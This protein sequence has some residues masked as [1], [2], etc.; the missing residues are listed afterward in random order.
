MTSKRSYVLTLAVVSVFA[1]L[2]SSGIIPLPLGLLIMLVAGGIWGVT[3]GMLLLRGG[4]F[5]L[6]K[7]LKEA[8]ETK[9]EAEQRAYRMRKGRSMCFYG[10]F[11]ILWGLLTPLLNL[12][13]FFCVLY[14]CVDGN[15]YIRLL[16][17]RIVYRV[18][19]LVISP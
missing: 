1:F 13:V 18:L 6:T 15:M 19:L 11:L 4:A 7:Q 14:Y 17:Q 8:M 10:A 9:P 5:R 3:Q 12:T 2:C 16:S